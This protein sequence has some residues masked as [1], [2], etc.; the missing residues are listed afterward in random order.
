MRKFISTIEASALRGKDIIKQVL[1]FARGAEGEFMT[2]QPKHLI[3]EMENIIKETFPK[4]IQLQANIQNDLWNISGNAT[5]LHQV[6][7]NLCVNA[8]DAML[9]GGTLSLSA[10]NIL[11]DE[12]YAR[13]IYN[14]KA[15]SYVLIKVSDSGIGISH[16]IREKI[17][18]PFFTTKDIGEG[19]G[20]GLSTA[21]TII[22]N[23]HGFIDVE[24]KVGKGTTLKVYIPAKITEEAKTAQAE[25]PK[26]PMGNGELIM[27]VDDETSV[28]DITSQTL[29][30]YGYNVVTATDGTDAISKYVDK[31]D[32]V[33]IVI[34]DILMPI[35]NGIATSRAL[36]KMNTNVKIILASG[37]R[38]NEPSIP[39]FDF[40][41]QGF[42]H[43][44]Y[45]A[46]T[47][48][49]TL[50]QVLSNQENRL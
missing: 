19:T 20:L 50:H 10:E 31:I 45:T 42:L 23:H 29:K 18:E 5:Q 24:S 32:T 16:Y 4:N 28:L 48:L 12:N 43:K 33:K 11:I 41:I 44:P 25:Q 37:L 22:K 14:M 21:L 26:L 27:I 36:R 8:R 46:E 2:L 38:H 35:M 1:T 47:L 30:N 13:M 17:F 39:K 7:L 15:G 6:L 40:K 34:T 49:K 9:D 3:K